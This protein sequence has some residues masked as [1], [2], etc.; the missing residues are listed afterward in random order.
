MRRVGGAAMPRRKLRLGVLYGGGRANC[1]YRGLLPL[2]ALARR[3]HAVRWLKAPS[4]VPSIDQLAGLDLVHAHR[5]LTPEHLDLFRALKAR[6]VAVVW[7][8]DDDLSAMPKITRKHDGLRRSGVRKLFQRTVEIA[9][10]AD[11]MTTPQ[12]ASR[13]ALPGRGRRARDGDR[14]RAAP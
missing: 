3:G 10:T 5:S 13:A 8:N 12:R 14:E 7:D 9:R 1:Y 6:G 11:L 4:E 2:E